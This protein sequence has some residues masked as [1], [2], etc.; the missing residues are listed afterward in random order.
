MLLRNSSYDLL[1]GRK[2][3]CFIV[4]QKSQDTQAMRSGKRGRLLPIVSTFLQGQAPFV[5][6]GGKFVNII[7]RQKPVGVHFGNRIAHFGNVAVIG[8]AVGNYQES[9]C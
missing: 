5:D 1:F 7:L 4:A 2:L 6:P 3:C 8:I 9:Q